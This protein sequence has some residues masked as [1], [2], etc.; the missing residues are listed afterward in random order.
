M[1]CW[2]FLPDFLTILT[3]I[4]KYI[5][6][7]GDIFISVPPLERKA[8]RKYRKLVIYDILDNK[9]KSKDLTF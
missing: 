3:V 8:L 2:F 4:S 7:L 1:D 6:Q 9:Q 5:L